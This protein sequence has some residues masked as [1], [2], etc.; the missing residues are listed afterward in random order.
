MMRVVYIIASVLLVISIGSCD[1]KKT[2]STN[3]NK[4]IEKENVYIG[5]D[6]L[7]NISYIYKS[8]SKMKNEP[9]I[10]NNEIIYFYPNGE[11]NYSKSVFVEIKNNNLYYHSPYNSKYKM[12]E[13]RFVFFKGNDSLKKDFS[14]IKKL[15][16]KG[17]N[18]N[19][20]GIIENYQSIIPKMGLIE[21]TIVL[22]TLIK[23]N[24][25]DKKIIR[26]IE[27]YVNINDILIKNITFP[28]RDKKLDIHK[29]KK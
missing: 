3:I 2:V 27:T 21:E 5:E 26:T 16:L 6:S 18:F 10:L 19:E 15:N 17:F 14:N 29:D 13:N 4:K 8:Y 23:S 7:G 1:K 11:I 12:G 24:K 9:F 28:K 20:K 22:D 25:G